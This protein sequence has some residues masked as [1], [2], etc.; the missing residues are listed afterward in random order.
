LHLDCDEYYL[1]DEFAR[2]RQWIETHQVP[3]TTCRLRTYFA[4]PGLQLEGFDDYCVPFI[5]RLNDTTVCGCEHYPLPVDPTRRINCADVTELDSSLI[6]MHHFSWVRRDIGRKI[7]NSSAD[8]L[9]GE[10]LAALLE[11]Y[12]AASPGKVVRH[13]NR[14][15]VEVKPPETFPRAGDFEVRTPTAS[16]P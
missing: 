2:A 1:P 9:S 7:R 13:W 10:R 11:D 8:H 6:C 3:G 12:E 4:S 14:Q 16:A 15:L 5:H